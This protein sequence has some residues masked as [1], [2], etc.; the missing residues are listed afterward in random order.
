MPKIV[1]TEIDNTTPG[2]LDEDFDVVYIP[3]F[4]DTTQSCLYN[5]NGDYVGLEPR[6]PT[7]FTSVS[8]FTSR[9]GT[10]PAKFS[11]RQDY[12]SLNTA[13][14]QGFASDAVPYD[15]VMFEAGEYDPSYIM[16]KELLSAGLNVV[17]E[18]INPDELTTDV[19]VNGDALV[20]AFDSTA[21]YKVEKVIYK[22]ISGAI[23]PSLYTH[24]DERVAFN[25]SAT[26]YVLVEGAYVEKTGQAI[27]DE[28]TEQ[29]GGEMQGFD[30]FY[31]LDAEVD[32]DTTTYYVD[33]E[34]ELYTLAKFYALTALEG[35][36]G[37][38][39]NGDVLT[40]V[41]GI[42]TAKQMSLYPLTKLPDDWNTQYYLTYYE[43]V[44]TLTVVKEESGKTIQE[45]VKSAITA[46]NKVT[47]NVPTVSIAVM[48]NT[49]PSVF[50]TSARD[51]L[52]DKGNYSIKYLTSGGYPVYEYNNGSLVT[53][54]LN[55]AENRGDCVAIIDH[56]D[57]LYRES[58]IDLPGSVYYAVKNDVS[59]EGKGDFGTMFT[60]WALY[61]RTTSDKNGN[62]V[63]PST[64]VRMSGGYAYLVALA[65]SIKTNAPWLAVAGSARG[66]VQ[67]LAQNGMTTNIPNGAADAMQPRS[68]GI[69]INAI[70]NIKP[71]GYTIWG[72]RTLKKN[73]EN[74]V[75]TSF[76][77]V[78]NLV[79]DVKKVCYR[80]ARK[81]TFEQNND[82]LWINFK[83]EIAPTLDRM[84]SGYGLSGYKLVRDTEH[85]RAAE[86]ATLCAKIFLYPVYPV[87]DFYVTIIL[88]DDEISVE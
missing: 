6:V 18:R 45:Q 12:R 80:A 60:P 81:L 23:A 88:Q 82:I 56:T 77:N 34:S 29:H 13:A 52:A 44:K 47:V 40:L 28:Y 78:R 69:A 10:A 42:E 51:G 38:S 61:N 4:V 1:I 70:T 20:P 31:A 86:K 17:Y 79:S 54:M 25:T 72:N 7:L 19:T 37:S 58:N 46:G 41:D 32:G 62:E 35:V 21:T 36:T 14:T 87:E 48:Y 15:Y 49:L 65:D 67:N 27:V 43:P 64:S 39:I 59:L 68:D 33:S 22:T 16:A 75:A 57:N 73:E 85:E 53:A 30:A 83:A 2:V 3:G 71:Y 74:L 84:V 55:L 26:Y 11:S 24:F 5:N 50:D 66:S 8:T 9:C 76:L 63:I